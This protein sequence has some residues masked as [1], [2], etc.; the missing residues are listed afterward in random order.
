MRR[1][2]LA[3][4]PA[5]IAVLAVLAP[6]MAHCS[7]DEPAKA[8]EAAREKDPSLPILRSLSMK[9]A[10]IDDTAELLGIKTWSG[11]FELRREARYARLVL[12]FYRDGQRVETFSTSAGILKATSRGEFAIQVVDLDYLPLGGG[13]PGHWQLSIKLNF[14]GTKGSSRLDVAKEKH[15]FGSGGTSQMSGSFAPK[16][17]T[18]TEVPLFWILYPR[19]DARSIEVRGDSPSEMIAQDRE[20][21]LMIARL[22][23]ESK[24]EKDGKS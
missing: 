23:V 13:K 7:A 20:G 14:A 22:I 17:G 19:P 15:L 11:A 16:A 10:A 24:G 5:L 2:S 3:M 1:F 6:T 8:R 9:E 21:T 12:D 4:A 18:P